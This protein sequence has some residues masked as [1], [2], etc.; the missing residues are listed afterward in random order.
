MVAGLQRW[1][2][3]RTTDR[4]TKL[5]VYCTLDHTSRRQRECFRAGGTG[6]A[7]RDVMFLVSPLWYDENGR[8]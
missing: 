6:G 1:C 7:E 4:H 2:G 5:R 8:A 3:G